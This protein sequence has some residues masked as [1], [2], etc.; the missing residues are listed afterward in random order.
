MNVTINKSTASKQFMLA[1][2]YT[3][4]KDNLSKKAQEKYKSV[5][6]PV[7]WFAEEKYDGY[8]ARYHPLE[9]KFYSRSGLNFP[10]KGDIP[11]WMLSAMPMVHLDGELYRGRGPEAF[12]K[13]GEIKRHNPSPQGWKGIKYVVFDLPEYDAPYS[14]RK[15]E[16]IKIVEQ[17]QSSWQE[18]IS[19]SDCPRW[20]KKTPCPIE[21]SPHSV[22]TS[23]SHLKAMMNEV[24][25]K[26]GEGLMLKDPNA[27]YEGKRSPYILKLKAE[28]DDEAIITGYDMGQGKY[29]GMLGAFVC[30]PLMPEINGKRKINQ[31]Y[32]F[33]IAGMTDSVRKTYKRTH[34]IGTI[35]TFQF[36]DRTV[37]GKPR[38]PRYQRIR[39]D[40]V[41]DSGK[42]NKTQNVVEIL[43]NIAKYEKTQKGGAF[44]V[45]NYRKAIASIQDID[46]LEEYTLQDLL[47]LEGVGKSIGEK[48]KEILDTGTCQYYE[49]TKGQ[50]NLKELFLGIQSVGPSKAKELEEKG[51]TS[52]QQLRENPS[53]LNNKQKIG[54][55]YYEDLLKRIPRTEG[56]KHEQLLLDTLNKVSN[57]KAE[58][59]VT[60]SYRRQA[61]ESGDIDFL[62]KIPGNDKSI[63][64][65]FINALHK[66]KYLTEHLAFGT[67]KYNGICK[68]G[69][70]HRRI[71]IMFCP[72]EEFPFSVFYF[73]GNGEFNIK[74]RKMVANKGF[75]LNEHGLFVTKKSGP[76]PRVQEN[77]TSEHDIFQ[78][79][80]IEY[81]EPTNR[82]PINL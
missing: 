51:F 81:I 40:V 43:E 75:R 28:Y 50:G 4:D 44:K 22:I 14:E 18:I 25:S 48:I 74:F 16:L 20:L 12:Q 47:K 9:Q 52:I 56:K 38:H 68:I 59:M 39:T 67:T 65:K 10:P 30:S 61:H 73:T 32:S 13:M 2:E 77:F 70:I 54:L 19:A 45:K 64:K 79:F 78:F 69:S 72:V 5:Q 41:L 63:F 27:K 55:K 11:E 26:G 3:T 29:T 8:R 60:G 66:R 80:D 33:T 7:N 36:N 37:S 6:P 53:L 21:Y 58:G 34:P 24:V 62:I 82:L 49:S 57:G 1:N 31:E 46:N 71:D 23:D 42:E 15:E 17:C 35:I 76:L